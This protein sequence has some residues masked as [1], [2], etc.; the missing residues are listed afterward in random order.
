MTT[1][2][3]PHCGQSV[4]DEYALCPYCG[5]NV[6]TS[7]R[8]ELAPK[9]KVAQTSGALTGAVLIVPAYYVLGAFSIM[10]HTMLHVSKTPQQQAH[11]MF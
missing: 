6:E 7:E 5:T 9:D 4:R 10:S 3:C 1:R 11:W 2:S 8:R